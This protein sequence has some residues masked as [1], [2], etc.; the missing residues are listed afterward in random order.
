MT[1]LKK[2]PPNFAKV[3]QKINEILQDIKDKEE[4]YQLSRITSFLA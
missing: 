3:L 1:P 4:R 2:L